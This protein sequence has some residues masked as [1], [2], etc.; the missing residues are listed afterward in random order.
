MRAAMVGLSQETGNLIEKRPQ[1]GEA[2]PTDPEEQLD[3]IDVLEKNL[4]RQI[5]AIRAS[6]VKITFLV[7]TM[8]GMLGFLA[9]SVSRA[10]SSGSAGLYGLLGTVPLIL[11]YV[12]LAL[13][14]IPRMKADS[15]SKVFFGGI[16]R[17][18]PDAYAA[19]MARLGST[20]YLAELAR[21]CHTTAKIARSKYRHVRNAYLAFFV[22]LPFWA[23]SIFLLNGK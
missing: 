16:A 19:A 20:E 15:R 6:D 7:P 21:E 23:T 14:V 10:P 3:R 2:G 8:T 9:A 4:S 13:T 22:S 17:E 1:T 18:S 11:A 12:F 5:E